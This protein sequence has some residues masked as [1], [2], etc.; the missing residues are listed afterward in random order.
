MKHWTSQTD[1]IARC[2]RASGAVDSSELVTRL[3]HTG[4]TPPNVEIFRR[5][6]LFFDKKKRHS[7]ICGDCDGVSLVRSSGLT[8]KEIIDRSN[9]LANKR[10]GRESRGALTAQV[11]ELRAISLENYGDQQ[12]IFVYDDPK[13][14]DELH[15]IMRADENITRPN[16][17]FIRD[18]I[19]SIFSKKIP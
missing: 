3:L 16:Q 11:S 8:D 5:S 12:I 17:D 9:E 19:N 6:E 15:A 1:K 4:N 10:D 2:D 14:D 18:R 13:S 7:N